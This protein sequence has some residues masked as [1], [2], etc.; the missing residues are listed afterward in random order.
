MHHDVPLDLVVD[1]LLDE[2]AHAQDQVKRVTARLK[3][4]A[5]ADRHRKATAVLSSVSGVGMLTAAAFRLEPAE[6]GRCGAGQW[7]RPPQTVSGTGPQP[8]K[9]LIIFVAG[10]ILLWRLSAHGELYRIYDVEFIYSQS[11]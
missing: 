6:P 3:E 9:K 8:S 7:P 10:L 11:Y 5:E 1:L 2:L 4:V